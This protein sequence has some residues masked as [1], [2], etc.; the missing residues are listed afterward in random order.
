[1]CQ[2]AVRGPATTRRRRFD[3][4]VGSQKR[5]NGDVMPGTFTLHLSLVFCG[6][7][8]LTLIFTSAKM[9]EV[10]HLF[11]C[12]FFHRRWLYHTAEPDVPPGQTSSAKAWATAHSKS[13]T[14]HRQQVGRQVES[15]HPLKLG[16]TAVFSGE[17][18]AYRRLVSYMRIVRVRVDCV[19]TV[20]PTCSHNPS[21]SLCR[22]SRK[23]RGTHC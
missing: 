2:G 23:S 22:V 1:M 3:V 20:Q 16:S 7:T 11:R 8:S 9:R 6:I 12:P 15:R 10:E 4:F 18:S 14:K 19:L 5:R 17:Q 13:D 21:T